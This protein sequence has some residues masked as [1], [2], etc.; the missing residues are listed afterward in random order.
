MNGKNPS[1]F[2]LYLI[3]LG[4]LG[5]S[6]QAAPTSAIDDA[7]VKSAGIRKLT[8]RH[9]TLYTDV[10]SG[11]EVD[12][13]PAVFDEAVPQWAAYFGVDESKTA[14]WRAR[15]FLIAD[16][17]RFDA[18]GLMPVGKD[19]FVNGISS[20]SDMWLYDQPTAYYRRHLLLHEGTH[21]FM[22]TFLGGC[23]PAWYMEGTAELMATHRLDQKGV[24][25]LFET[26]KRRENEKVPDTFLHL[27]I[28]PRD[29][30]DVPMLGRIK[31][32]HDAIADGRAL[33]L[34][35]VLALD[36]REQLGNEAYAWCWAAAKFLDSN[37]QYRDRFRKLKEHVLDPNFNSIVRRNFA[38]WRNLNAE[39]RAYVATLDHD[40]D[41]DRMAIRFE[42]GKPLGDRP[43]Y[44]TV[45]ADRGWQSSGVWLEAN[46]SYR[47]AAHG[48][49]QIAAEDNGGVVQPWPCEPGGV[50]VEYHEGKP[51]GIL[52]GAI[53]ARQN[54]D[55]AVVRGS[56]DPAQ[57]S[58]R[59]PVGEV[60]RSGDRPQQS[61]M[62]SN[63]IV[64]GLHTTIRPTTSGTLYLRVNDS[65]GRLHDNRGTL[66][67]KIEA[68]RDQPS[69]R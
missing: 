8:S 33:D 56:P 30:T 11:R 13:L 59:P 47:I 29:R 19:Q 54:G 61:A 5:G 58:V 16:R 31:L 20:G 39:W 21:A 36:G 44:I 15:A 3:A 63:P 48:R 38:D 14:S 22:T 52:L 18:L 41:F 66:T 12:R 68:A 67:V 6:I 55:G 42:R 10:P 2:I 40:Y 9:L 1:S 57:A 24:R 32:I 17:R 46:Q 65:G 69:R 60:A 49:Y 53:D 64:I 23:G 50:T 28:M 45:A 25:N 51:L 4:V 26:R 43:K 34:P 62:F 7:R 35:A 37:P 27:N